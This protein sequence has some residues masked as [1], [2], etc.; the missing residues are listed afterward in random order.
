MCLAQSWVAACPALTPLVCFLHLWWH[1]WYDPGSVGGC[2]AEYQ[3][4]YKPLTMTPA[5]GPSHQGSVFFPIPDGSGLLYKL[6]GQVGRGQGSTGHCLGQY[7]I[8]SV[9]IGH[10][11]YCVSACHQALKGMPC[12][13]Q[14]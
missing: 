2:S 12:S 10:V 9:S 3:L 1:V 13:T 7:R 4:L 8:L 11:G 6:L 14:S 5:D